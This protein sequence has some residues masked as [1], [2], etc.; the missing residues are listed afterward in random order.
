MGFPIVIGAVLRVDVRGWD[1]PAPVLH[2]APINSEDGTDGTRSF[3]YDF[4]P[5]SDGDLTVE[6]FCARVTSRLERHLTGEN[7]AFAEGAFARRMVLEVGLMVED[8]DERFAMQWPPDFLA[9]LG[10][11]ETAL[12]LTFYTVPGDNDLKGAVDSIQAG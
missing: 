2:D 5:S 7:A 10:E 4:M 11:A 3:F 12:S 8:T 1:R 6:P 9:V